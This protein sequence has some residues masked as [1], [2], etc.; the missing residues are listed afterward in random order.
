MPAGPA[1]PSQSSPRC[2]ASSRTR[3][4]HAR[5]PTIASVRSTARA[6]LDGFETRYP[7]ARDLHSRA[8]ELRLTARVGARRLDGVDGDL[9]RYLAGAPAGPDR[10]RTLAYLG[11]ELAAEA[12]RAGPQ[13]G[14]PA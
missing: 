12:E 6:L 11:R 8:L 5:P 7:E 4:G 2:S 3:P 13:A 9:A 14:A 1:S 10:R